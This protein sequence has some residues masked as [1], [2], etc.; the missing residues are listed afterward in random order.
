MLPA[1]LRGRVNSA[2]AKHSWT[3]PL[4]PL[5]LAPPPSSGGMISSLVSSS[6]SS[7][8]NDQPPP[9]RSRTAR[10][11]SSSSS[12]GSSSNSP[13]KSPRRLRDL[14]SSPPPPLILPS[15]P[16]PTPNGG[17][18]STS[19]SASRSGSDRIIQDGLLQL[20]LSPITTS[21]PGAIQTLLSP[22]SAMLGLATPNTNLNTPH[23]FPS[24][25]S[26]PQP[27]PHAPPPPSV[28]FIRALFR[29]MIRLVTRLTCGCASVIWSRV[30]IPSMS[31]CGRVIHRCCCARCRSRRCD[32]YCN[33]HNGTPRCCTCCTCCS[34]CRLQSRSPHHR[35]YR[36]HSSSNSVS[37]ASS[38]ITEPQ[39]VY[40]ESNIKSSILTPPSSSM[41]QR[42][43]RPVSFSFS[44]TPSSQSSSS[45]SPAFSS[46][47]L[48]LPSSSLSAEGFNTDNQ[49]V[50]KIS[51]TND[52]ILN[53]GNSVSSLSIFPP[54]PLSS[55]GSSF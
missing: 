8:S 21:P 39:D 31:A 33:H 17:S 2:A 38:P 55:S 45:L 52:D 29:F 20:P 36:T 19:S 51:I 27:T 7:S 24:P 44:S 14:L 53:E 13:G 1:S 37:F 43:P 40:S 42:R 9:P 15:S 23:Q 30:V 32:K 11:A 47:V 48:R 16:L 25:L 5:F 18:N 6:S 49:G 26:S 46:V 4:A 50:D 10:A 12:N 22:T 3:A 34:C 28:G 54:S 35:H 41:R